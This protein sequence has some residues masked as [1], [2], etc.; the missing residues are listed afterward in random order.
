MQQIPTSPR[1]KALV[2]LGVF[3]LVGLALVTLYADGFQQDSSYHFL[4]ARW[5]WR[6]HYMF[7]GVWQ[8]P[9]FT[10]IY[11]FPTLLG[12][13]AA[14]LFTVAICLATAWQT[15]K[16]A[17]DLKLERSWLVIPLL[18]L[19]PS[20]FV[21]FAD[22]LTETLFALV[23][24]IAL[25][26][27][28]RGR[29]KLGMVV[30]SLL[31]MA[32]PEGFFLGALWGVWILFDKR[33]S[34]VFWRRIP[35]SLLLAVGSFIWWLAAY[36]I[37]KDPLFIKNNWPSDW[38][39]GVYGSAHIWSYP[40]RLP[41]MVGGLLIV[42]FLVGL[43]LLLKR[44]EQIPLTTSFL[45]LFLLHTIFWTFGMVGEA[46]YPRYMV[47]VA[48]A[49][50]LITLIGWKVMAEWGQQFSARARLATAGTVLFISAAL[51]VGY[52]DGMPWPRD[53]WAI[54]EMHQWFRQN[55]RPVTKLVWSHAMMCA[56]FNI[57]MTTR[58]YLSNNREANQ[59]LLS[60]APS[61]TL[62]F[63]DSEIGPKWYN[64]TD[65]DFESIGYKRLR[66]HS[67]SLTGYLWTD[68]KGRM[69]GTR[70]L[71]LHLFYKE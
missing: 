16:L 18:F 52:M 35:W 28:T 33:V 9:L 6:Y 20:F 49:M 29:V 47:S 67:Y 56:V 15:W 11:A 63:W 34:T 27:H 66:S 32:R 51:C 43:A 60:E 42:P 17:Q 7:V 39:E 30:A 68:W 31:I 26:L 2:W 58:P 8:R 5:A 23:F 46:G 69:M 53:G 62:I 40:L 19:Q 37:T 22:L 24:V 21:L 41:E 71:D 3:A 25:R 14:R 1:K 38:H 59:K 10:F 44:R 36:I 45:L 55:E 61:G 54:K 64:L 50:A 57:D 13:Q 4:F 70:K 12:Y 65:Q 48:P